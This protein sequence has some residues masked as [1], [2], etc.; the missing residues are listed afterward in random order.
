MIDYLLTWTMV[1]AISTALMT[2]AIIITVIIAMNELKRGL[3]SRRENLSYK[4]SERWFK[5]EYFDKYEK[6]AEFV[7]EELDKCLEDIF[8]TRSGELVMFPSEIYRLHKKYKKIIFAFKSIE[9]F[10]ITLEYYLKNGK[11][12][13]EDIND[14]SNIFGSDDD[15]ISNFY[16]NLKEFELMFYYAEQCKVNKITN[17]GIIDGPGYIID[18]EKFFINRELPIDIFF[19]RLAKYCQNE[20]LI[21][22]IENYNNKYCK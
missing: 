10:I 6:I 11:L 17:H 12:K 18:L 3:T 7:N 1:N 20:S 13:K 9:N 2:I 8:K 22:E 5:G 19:T 16:H 15:S 21:C 4:L 14:F